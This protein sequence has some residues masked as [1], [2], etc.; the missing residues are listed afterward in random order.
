MHVVCHTHKKRVLFF[1]FEG[2]ARKSRG[3]VVRHRSDGERC[4]FPLMAEGKLIL[5]LIHE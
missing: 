4:G 1:L 5:S 3:R 2:N